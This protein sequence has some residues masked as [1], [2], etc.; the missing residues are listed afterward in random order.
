MKSNVLLIL[1]LIMYSASASCKDNN[2]TSSYDEDKTIAIHTSMMLPFE[3]SIAYGLNTY[4]GTK[5]DSDSDFMELS[6]S[7]YPL[8]YA[9]VSMGLM[10]DNMGDG[11]ML[12]DWIF[13]DD[14]EDQ[15]H[16]IDHLVRFSIT[17]SMAFRSPV[18]WL[19]HGHDYGLMLGFRPGLVMSFPV[20]DSMWYT[21]Y[22]GMQNN[23]V[24]FDDIKLKNRGGRWLAWRVNTYLS[25]WFSNTM[26]VALGYMRSNYNILSC[27]N[28]MSYNGRLIYDKQTTSAYTNSLYLRLSVCF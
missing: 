23:H 16:D 19:N 14:D 10:V 15:E 12:V 26:S 4:I 18:L 2:R 7:Y 3:A 24:V 27:R 22:L 1:L 17:P 8:Q 20:N 5:Y 28:N 25:F 11:S 6:L 21:E 9:G 13:D